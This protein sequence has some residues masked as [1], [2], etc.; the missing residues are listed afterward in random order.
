MMYFNMIRIGDSKTNK[1]SINVF[2]LV[3]KNNFLGFFY[4]KKLFSFIDSQ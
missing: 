2:M 3:H 4:F 1:C